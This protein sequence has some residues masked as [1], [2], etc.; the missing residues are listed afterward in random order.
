MPGGKYVLPK[1]KYGYGELAP[2]LSEQQLAIHHGKHHAA[3]V[4]GAN[5][6]YDKLDAARSSGADLD[7]KAIAKELAFNSG[8]HVLHS[9]FWENMAPAGKGGGGVPEAGSAI[10]DA[11]KNEFGSFERFKTEF[12]KIA[13]SVE[14]SGWAVLAYGK[15]T[16]RPVIM[17][18]EKHNV[19]FAP[20]L[21][22]LLVI[23]VWEHAYYL[24]YKNERPR[25]VDAFWNVVDWNAVNERLKKV[26]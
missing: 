8:G 25:F 20:G 22:P 23:D 12:S 10:G 13:V 19:N 9:L 1:L 14:G 7:F 3:Y 26:L 21:K 6:I 11:I 2:F 17:Q 4:N 24:D 5:A 18:V 16:Q 15:M